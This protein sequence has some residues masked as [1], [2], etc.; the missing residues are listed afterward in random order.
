MSDLETT[1]QPD[2]SSTA[3][4]N[5][6]ANSLDLTLSV[7]TVWQALNRQEPTIT[8]IVFDGRT[9]VVHLVHNLSPCIFPKFVR[10]QV[11]AI[12]TLHFQETEQDSGLLKIYKQ[13]DSWTVEGVIQSVP[14]VS[15]WYNH[16]LRVMMGKILTTTGDLLDAA[17]THAQ[18]MSL[19][20]REIQ[21]VGRDMA[22][23]N[24]EKLE[25]YRASLHENYLEGM[26]GWRECYVQELDVP[27]REDL[28]LYREDLVEGTILLED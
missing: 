11:P 17:L 8:N 18:K 25:E 10:L 14:L 23:E 6:P 24:M 2:A 7:Y 9:A 15:F 27:N 19:R 26:R 3:L 21:R 5:N 20:G 22:V 4:I 13:E 28:V 12:T 1:A 16:V